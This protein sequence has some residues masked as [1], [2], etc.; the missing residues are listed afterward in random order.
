MCSY[1]REV[2][3]LERFADEVNSDELSELT[4]SDNESLADEDHNLVSDHESDTEQESF[5]DV[6]EQANL[7]RR[8]RSKYFYGK[9]GT[10]WSKEAAPLNVRTRQ[11]NIVT[12]LPGVLGLAK[13]GKTPMQCWLYFFEEIVNVIVVNT[14]P[15]ITKIS[16]RYQDQYDYKE[17]N[18]T[19][20]M[21]LLDLLYLA[22]SQHGGRKHIAEFYSDNG[23][24]C[25]IFPAAMAQR[26]VKFLLRCLRFDDTNTRE[27]RKSQD[28]LAAVREM[29]IK[30]NEQC[31]VHYSVGE[32][33]TL[34]EMLL[35]FRG[36]CRFKMYIPNKPNKYGLKVF[37]MVDSRTFYTSHLEIYAGTQ[38]E[39]PFKIDNSTAAVTERMCMHL[40]GSGRNVTMDRWFTGYKIASL[41]LREHRLTV[42]ATIRANRRELPLEITQVKNRKVNSSLFAF[43]K[44]MMAVSYV[45]KKS[46][47]VLLISS[48]HN[49]TAIDQS[50]GEKAKP[51]VVSFYNMTKGGVDVLDRMITA[52]N[53]A[54]NTRRWPMVI[55]YGLMNV[56]AINAFIIYKAN[57]PDG[58]FSK[59]RRMFLKNLETSLL[60]EN[61][62]QRAVNA[63]LPRKVQ[64]MIKILLITRNRK[65]YD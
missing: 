20:I 10:K 28:N 51:E 36:R 17:T 54:R 3:R 26:R 56:A 47:N 2:K 7:L 33:V 43:S 22:G 8:S 58:E 1:E 63:R 57:S 40:S 18:T 19:E 29:M 44:D 55:F 25:E 13:N 52:Y 45:P 50:T 4:E 9:D 37:S 39:G 46:K 42:V 15:Y 64:R 16:N 31:K 61:M 11:R 30:F 62:R 32:Y 6:E 21:A 12:H 27:V 5:S 38:P 14:N 35:A 48:M 53:P 60:K 23:L 49:D 65:F 59:S 41:L 24:G 34:D